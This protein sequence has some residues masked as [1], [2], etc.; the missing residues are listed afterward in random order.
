MVGSGYPSLLGC[1]E[2]E[3]GDVNCL[4]NATE[5]VDGDEENSIFLDKC[6][7]HPEHR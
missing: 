5:G 7:I 3:N 1:V 6:I 2:K 4:D